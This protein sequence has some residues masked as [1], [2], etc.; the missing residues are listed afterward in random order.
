MPQPVRESF[1]THPARFAKS[2][3]IL[4]T[5]VL[6]IA[7]PVLVTNTASVQQVGEYFSGQLYFFK[8]FLVDGFFNAWVS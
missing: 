8:Y 2:L 6:L 4:C 5:I 1:F 7:P 3:T